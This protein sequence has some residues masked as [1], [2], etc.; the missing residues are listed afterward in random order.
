MPDIFDFTDFREYLQRF[1]EEKKKENPHY[2][3]ELLARKAGF[4]N[5]GFVFNI[6]KVRKY[7]SASNCFKLSKALGHN[8]KEAEYFR[9]LVE[10]AQAKNEEERTLLLEQLRLSGNKTEITTVTIDKDQYEYLS[11]WY[12]SA[13]RALIGIFPVSNNYE[14]ISKKIFP[15]ITADQAK[16]SIELLERLKLIT[17]GNDGR[18]C[19]TG[20]IIRSGNEPSQAAINRFHIECTELAKQSVIYSASGQHFVSSLTLGISERSYKLIC[21]ETMQFKEKILDIAAH[22]EEADRVYQYQ[23]VFFPLTKIYSTKENKT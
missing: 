16:K 4:N 18:Y 10:F 1:F 21:E 15:P 12:H 9:K 14:E 23:L 20:K 19:V 7:L 6:I 11:K 8:K 17:R 13:V 3:Y 2:T 22:D 5:R